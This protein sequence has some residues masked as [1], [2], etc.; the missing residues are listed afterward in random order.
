MKFKTL[1]RVVFQVTVNNPGAPGEWKAYADFTVNRKMID[2]L[3]WSGILAA[4]FFQNV[5]GL[6]RFD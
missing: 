5:L 2:E 6:K 1:D 3:E 4:D